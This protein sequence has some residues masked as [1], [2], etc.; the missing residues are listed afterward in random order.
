MHINTCRKLE[1]NSWNFNREI[2]I[3]F[4]SLIIEY[5]ACSLQCLELRVELDAEKCRK[6]DGNVI[7][8][9]KCRK[10]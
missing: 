3:E 7:S 8:V 4:L 5:L 9:V 10:I 2:S 6:I 1:T